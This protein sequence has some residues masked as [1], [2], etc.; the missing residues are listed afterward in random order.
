MT[1]KEKPSRFA[2]TAIDT[3]LAHAAYGLEHGVVDEK[4]AA[5]WD[6]HTAFMD[7]IVRHPMTLYTSAPNRA[8]S[9]S[10]TT[11]PEKDTL[12]ARD[13]V[14]LVYDTLNLIDSQRP[15]D[16]RGLWRYS[17]VAESF[18]TKQFFQRNIPKKPK[19]AVKPQIP[20]A[21]KAQID[22]HYSDVRSFTNILRT[23]EVIK[24]R[25]GEDGKRYINSTQVL[26]IAAA[27]HT[28]AANQQ[29]YRPNGDFTPESL[30]ALVTDTGETMADTELANVAIVFNTKNILS[31][32][33]QE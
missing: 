19:D 18:T 10:P 2:N 31:K 9:T 15:K 6:K 16:E 26:A 8:E 24:T 5:A 28:L 29:S 21:I 30:Q 11:E 1:L 4:L 3:D 25:R 23:L 14:R 27:L 7:A 13:Y 20:E 22:L 17:D 12:S 32:I 33:T